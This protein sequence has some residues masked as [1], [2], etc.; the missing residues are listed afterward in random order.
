M[1][2]VTV[3]CFALHASVYIYIKTKRYTAQKHFVHMKYAP[4]WALP[5]TGLVLSTTKLTVAYILS[6]LIIVPSY[7][8][9][10]GFCITSALSH[11]LGLEGPIRAFVHYSCGTL[12]CLREQDSLALPG[13]DL[14]S[15]AGSSAMPMPLR[16]I[17]S[18]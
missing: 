13:A 2:E 11:V 3:G 8:R 17:V 14:V 18:L 1:I 16:S 7:M 10:L 4:S 6:I 15:D 12:M 9:F 5:K